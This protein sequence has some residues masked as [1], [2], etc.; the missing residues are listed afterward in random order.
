MIPGIS[1]FANT[2]PTTRPAAPR[3]RAMT[4]TLRVAPVRRPTRV[5]VATPRAF[6]LMA[7]GL[8]SRRVNAGDQTQVTY[9]SRPGRPQ[10]SPEIR[11]LVLRL[12]QSP[13]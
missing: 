1:S 13:R 5:R 2:G 9:P 7:G 10:A 4:G 11:D 8:A 6:S 3:Y 12:A